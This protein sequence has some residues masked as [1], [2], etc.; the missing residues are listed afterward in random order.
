MEAIISILGRR[1][2]VDG[3]AHAWKSED[4]LALGTAVELNSA[5]RGNGDCVTIVGART[6]SDWV[7]GVALVVR[8]RVR[9]YRPCK[10]HTGEC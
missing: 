5:A 7:A 1:F 6:G 2:V 9:N 10:G 3:S 4:G 8:P